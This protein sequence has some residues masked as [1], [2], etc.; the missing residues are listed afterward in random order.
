MARTPT[1]TMSPSSVQA[2]I[3]ASPRITARRPA[4]LFAKLSGAPVHTNSNIIR[5]EG[6]NQVEALIVESKRHGSLRIEC[7]GIIVTRKSFKQI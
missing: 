5:I 2:L 7:D 1:Y 6:K 4:L 3:E